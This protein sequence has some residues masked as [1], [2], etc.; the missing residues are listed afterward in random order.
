MAKNDALERAKALLGNKYDDKRKELPAGTASLERAREVL[1][2]KS[3]LDVYV[4]FDTTG[5]MDSYVDAVRKDIGDVTASVLDGKSDIRLSINGV[6]DHCD[7]DDVIQMYALTNKPEEVYGSIE[8][9]AMTGGGDEPEAY[10]CMALAMA[11]RIPNESAGRKRA[12][13]FIGDSVPHGII[14]EPCECNVD[15]ENAFKAMK[16]VC[17]GFYFVGCNQGSYKY[18]K[19]LIET[20]TE[21]EQFIPLGSMVGTLPQ[22]L[23]ALAKKSE[24]EKAFNDYMKLLEASNAGQAGKIKGLLGKG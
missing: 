13:V 7:G 2:T 22:L 4:V 11:E 19:K 21:K 8:N 17:D 5:S 15:Y 20:G 18:Q 1:S 12:V 9:I 3:G 16:M 23:I 24:S 10:E 14:D 6:G